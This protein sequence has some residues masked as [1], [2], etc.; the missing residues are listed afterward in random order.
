MITLDTND[1]E[2]CTC[3]CGTIKLE[4]VANAKSPTLLIMATC[5]NDDCKRYVMTSHWE[6]VAKWWN[7]HSGD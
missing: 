1:M 3:G 4:Q 5:A 6:D 7:Q 2:P